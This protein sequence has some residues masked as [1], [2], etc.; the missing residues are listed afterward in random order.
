MSLESILPNLKPTLSIAA[1]RRKY[2]E[3]YVTTSLALRAEQQRFAFRDSTHTAPP[4][5]LHLQSPQ[6]YFVLP[7]ALGPS[8]LDCSLDPVA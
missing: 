3:Y 1:H 2:H 5:P 4:A 7:K 6:P 8:S